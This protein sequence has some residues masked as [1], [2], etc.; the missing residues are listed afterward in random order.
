MANFGHYSESANF[1]AVAKSHTKHMKPAGSAAPIKI[2]A[3]RKGLLHSKLDVPQGKKIP[4]SKLEAAKHSK[5]AALRKEANFAI[6]A[7]KFNH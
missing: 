1:D 7:K 5:S 3:S 2:K 6:N 4:D